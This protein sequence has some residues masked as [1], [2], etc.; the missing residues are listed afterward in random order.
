MPKKLTKRQMEKVVVRAIKQFNAY[1]DNLFVKSKATLFDD[2]KDDL[3][4]RKKMIIGLLSE[5]LGD[6]PS[7]EEMDRV[8]ILFRGLLL[9]LKY[10]DN[11]FIQPLIADDVFSWYCEKKFVD[12]KKGVIVEIMDKDEIVFTGSSGD[13]DD[14]DVIRI[15][16]D[17]IV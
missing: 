15:D 8:D 11:V 6:A 16:V 5:F 10:T 14:A 17:E 13:I 3:V 1:K 2:A 12:P 9:G 7:L 4:G